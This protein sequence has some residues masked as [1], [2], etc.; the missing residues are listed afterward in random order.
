MFLKILNY[1]NLFLIFHRKMIFTMFNQISKQRVALRNCRPWRWCPSSWLGIPCQGSCPA[2]M[3]QCSQERHLLFAILSVG[4]HQAPPRT[5]YSSIS[6]SD[7][8]GDLHGY[9]AS[10]PHT[11]HH[12]QTIG[13][14]DTLSHYMLAHIIGICRY[15]CA[16]LGGGIL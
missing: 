9:T 16:L 11:K 1:L 7:N 8:T 2:S 5:A 6:F 3:S 14:K 13:A 12:T 4:S 10:I 15:F